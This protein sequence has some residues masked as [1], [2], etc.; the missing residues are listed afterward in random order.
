MAAALLMLL[1]GSTRPLKKDPKVFR[2]FSKSMEFDSV[3]CKIV[4][5]FVNSNESW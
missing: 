1:T 2:S 5:I 4:C 3:S